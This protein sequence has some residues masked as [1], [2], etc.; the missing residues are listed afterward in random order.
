MKNVRSVFTKIASVVIILFFCTTCAK[1]YSYEGGNRN[2]SATG[3]AEYTLTGAGGTCTGSIVA[4]NYYA[5]KTLSTFNTVT[6]EVDVSVIGSYTIHTNGLDGFQFSVVGNFT[7]TGKQSIVLTGNGVP[8]ANGT[9]NFTTPVGLGCT[10]TITVTDEPPPIAAY[11][12]T[13]APNSCMDAKIN[14]LYIAGKDLDA[15]NSISILVT[16]SSPG[17]YI[18]TTDTL[19]GF[20]FYAKGSFA[21]TGTQT[22]TLQGMGTPV[23]A[24]NFNFKLSGSNSSCT[25][26]IGVVPSGINA[27]YVLESGSNTLCISTPVTWTAKAGTPL[28]SSDTVSIRVYVTVPGSFAIATSSVNGISFYYTGTFTQIGLQYVVLTGSGVPMSSGTS[29]LVPSIVGPHPLGGEICGIN[30]TV[31]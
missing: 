26:N 7:V 10:F 17:S 21:D 25:L 29:K 1:E 28:N 13:G 11:T 23:F 24:N 4:G 12:L 19:N 8:V 22:V 6:L 30:V 31:L 5:G 2:G 27:T 14:G 15:T 9:Y 20:F 3:T 16:V 18:L